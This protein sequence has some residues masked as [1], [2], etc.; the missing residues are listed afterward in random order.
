LFAHGTRAGRHSPFFCQLL[1][2]A[3]VF[4]PG[5]PPTVR[6]INPKFAGQLSPDILGRLG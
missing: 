1:H 2:T 3:G 4:P 6:M 5:A